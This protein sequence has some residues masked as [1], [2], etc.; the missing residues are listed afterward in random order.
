MAFSTK[1]LEE[2]W[3][4]GTTTVLL[5]PCK[6]DQEWFHNLWNAEDV[7]IEFRWVKGR[8]KFEGNKHAA[9]FPCVIIVVRPI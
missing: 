9:A 2:A 8:V 4:H 3:L 5:V 1:A 6:T 7:G